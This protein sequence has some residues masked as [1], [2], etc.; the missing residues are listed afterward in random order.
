MSGEKW[1][2]ELGLEIVGYNSI[3]PI[4]VE[5]SSEDEAIRKAKKI[6]E[7][8]YDWEFIEEELQP[9]LSVKIDRVKKVR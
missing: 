5:A 4:V 2:I 6:I 8:K 3:K 7:E 9:I 1:V